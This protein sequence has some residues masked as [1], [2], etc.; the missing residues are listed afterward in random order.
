MPG[1]RLRTWSVNLNHQTTHCLFHRCCQK[2]LRDQKLLS[3]T[4][5]KNE[6]MRQTY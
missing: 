2:Q 3:I 5:F 6:N 4:A 1:D